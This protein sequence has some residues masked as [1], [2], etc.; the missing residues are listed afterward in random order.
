MDFP[1]FPIDI[2]SL[3]AQF[4]S[5]R[6]GGPVF[7]DNPGGTQAPERVIDAVSDYWRESCANVGGAF[8]TSQR[9]DAV[10]AGARAAMA[11]LLGASDPAE[12][13]FGASMTALTFHLARSFGETL[14]PGDE[15][16]VTALDHDANVAPWRGLQSR[17]AAVETVPFDPQTGAID[18]KEIERRLRP[19]KTK[20]LA[21]TAASN[22]L[23]TMP[24]VKEATRLAHA[25]GALVF[26]DGVQSV[27]HVP[28][29]VREIGCDFLVCSAYKFF[30]PHVGVLWGKREHLERLTPS[31]VRPSK[32]TIP[33]RW[34]Q[35]TLNHEG[36]AG[37]RAAV[38][39]IESLGAGE[40]RRE[41]LTSAMTA[42]HAY[43]SA[44]CARLLRGLAEIP[45]VRVYGPGE[46]GRVPTVAFTWPRH[47]PRG[48]CERLAERG[49]CAWSGNYYAVG[50]METLGLSEGAV[51][52]G[53]AHYN[54]AE[55][56]D[57]LL[58]VLAE[59]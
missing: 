10:V 14:A 21:I 36:L 5:I 20:L 16:L 44:L 49:F 33:Y 48:T 38:A 19:G 17:G 2:D 1:H 11:D 45:G 58:H 23:G 18:L 59:L 22:A 35:G 31:K 39:H 52:L 43:E 25:A 54:T 55:E 4:P 53:L 12:I 3:R 27:P 6:V 51:R 26:I 56:V 29:D 42:I 41:R 32:D 24:D 37:V 40:T 47:S 50:A 15:I 46:S 30:G 8:L 28:T 34:E 57:S 13:V 9:T 7:F